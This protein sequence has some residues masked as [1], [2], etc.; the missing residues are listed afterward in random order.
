MGFGDAG[1]AWGWVCGPEEA[2]FIDSLC[3]SFAWKEY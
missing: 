1:F 2:A 3:A